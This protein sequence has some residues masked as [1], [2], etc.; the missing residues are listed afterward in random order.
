MGLELG[1]EPPHINVVDLPPPPPRRL[2]V[3]LFHL[4]PRVFSKAI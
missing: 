2:A 1:A 3:F 4:I